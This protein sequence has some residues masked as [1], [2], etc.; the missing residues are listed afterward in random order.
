MEASPRR[1]IAVI[2]DEPAIRV[3]VERFLSDGGYRVVSTGEP[4][5]AVDMVRREDPDLVLCDIAM[6]LMDGYQVLKA[7]QAD[8]QTAR[9]PVVFLTANREFSERVQ[10]FRFGVV[11]YMTKPFTREVLLRKVERVLR[12]LDRRPGLLTG[13]GETA[14]NLLEEAKREARTGILSVRVEGGESRTVLQAGTVVERTAPFLGEATGRAEFQE[15]DPNC[16]QIV[17]HEPTSLPAT[18]GGLPSFESF[19]EH[20][21]SVLVIDDNDLFRRFLRDLLRLQGFAVH[22]AASGEEGLDLALEERPWL[23][24]TDVKLPGIDGIEFCRRVRS[25]SLIR[26]TPLIFLSGWDDYK[27]RYEGLEAGADEF[28]S[29]QTP[30]RELLIRIQLLLRRLLDMGTRGRRG[31]G[32]EG[33][34]DVIGAPGFLQMCHLGRLSGTCAVRSGDRVLSILFR[35]GDIVGA[36]SGAEQGADA[37]FDFLAWTDG[38]FE[39]TP[40]DPGPG[41]PL[42]ETFDQLILEGC[43][44]LDEQGRN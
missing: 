3:L 32:M 36:D 8:P 12:G 31:A 20:L 37:I 39:F 13:D 42:G 24:L 11:D 43:R 28:L 41:A 9:H 27:Q 40:G 22:E 17:P 35:D 21:R 18:G 38:H 33:G 5:T 16:E 15:L 2:E 29:K 25:L 1:T 23:I 19:P 6:P 10:A 7:L 14:E 26:H 30:V 34:I 44:R 4:M